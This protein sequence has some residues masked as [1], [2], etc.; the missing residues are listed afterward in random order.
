[1][2]TH[3]GG[4][5]KIRISLPAAGA[6][7]ELRFRD[8]PVV[9]MTARTGVEEKLRAL[10]GKERLASLG[11]LAGAVC[12]E[13]LNPLSIILGALENASAINNE[14]APESLARVPVFLGYAEQSA[15]R[16]GRTVRA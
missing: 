2:T 14:G 13:V 7:A 1:L 3:E 8:I 4:R 5:L 12:H 10:R 11:I 6:E 9:L 15:T 16:I